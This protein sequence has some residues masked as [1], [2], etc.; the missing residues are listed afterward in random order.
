MFKPGDI[1]LRIAIDYKGDLK[2]NKLYLVEYIRE[3][4]SPIYNTIKLVGY[5]NYY[6]E[7]CF[8]LIGNSKL[9]KLFF[10]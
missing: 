3:T 6:F 2:Q 10:I 7:S 8:K 9:A 4:N 1:V 5:K